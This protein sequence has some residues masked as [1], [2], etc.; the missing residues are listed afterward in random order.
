MNPELRRVESDKFYRY[1]TYL[2]GKSTMI[3]YYIRYQVVI[4]YFYNPVNDSLDDLMFFRV[5]EGRVL[6][7]L[8][9]VY[10]SYLRLRKQVANLGYVFMRMF[11]F[12][13]LTNY[14]HHGIIDQDLRLE[15]GPHRLF[16]HRN[17]RRLHP[18]IKNLTTGEQ[19]FYFE[20]A[21]V[22]EKICTPNYINFLP[23][24]VG[25][26]NRRYLF[27]RRDT[28][29][30][31]SHTYGMPI[32]STKLCDLPNCPC[33]NIGWVGVCDSCGYFMHSC[34]YT[35]CKY[36]YSTGGTG[37]NL[38]ALRTHIK[39]YH[40]NNPKSQLLL[41]PLEKEP[42]DEEVEEGIEQSLVNLFLRERDFYK[43]TEF[44]PMFD[45]FIPFKV[46]L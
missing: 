12:P 27:C 13:P 33:Y 6:H 44:K 37:R 18:W 24:R 3:R 15:D 16:V 29:Q 2:Y 19:K 38:G 11:C 45:V 23:V 7:F 40:L 31:D 1:V 20:A 17:F 28:K 39:K 26:E 41:V 25:F 8:A 22:I 42:L 43:Q 4:V 14:D 21:E 35:P 30:S 5:L 46:T 9:D 34:P 36:I 32:Y 10:K